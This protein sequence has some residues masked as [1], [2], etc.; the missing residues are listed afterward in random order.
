MERYVGTFVYFNFTVK[1]KIEKLVVPKVLLQTTGVYQI[2]PKLN[3]IAMLCVS[4]P[5]SHPF[6]YKVLQEV[7]VVYKQYK[8]YNFISYKQAESTN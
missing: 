1:L 2:K 4:C 5:Y 3:L 7:Y 8:F 6:V